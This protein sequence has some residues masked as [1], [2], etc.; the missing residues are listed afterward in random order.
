MDKP[1][2]KYLSLCCSC[3]V[4]RSCPT[5]CNPMDCNM[6]G[7][8]IP[9]LLLEF[10]QGHVHCISDA[11]QPSH[12]LM[13]SSSTLNLSQHEGL[14]QWVRFSSQLTKIL[15]LHLQ[16]QFFQWISGLI[17]LRI[18]WFDLLVVLAIQGTQELPGHMSGENHN[19]KRYM[20][21]NVHNSAIYNRQ[22][23]EAT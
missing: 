5:L 13:P 22:D 16:H 15:E 20:L 4:T 21:P 2:G 1:W 6:P 3:S 7:L 18:D 8:P 10:A 12:P 11:I 14:F 19:S 23:I 17:S 9:H